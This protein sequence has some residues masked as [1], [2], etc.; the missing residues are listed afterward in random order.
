MKLCAE[1][2]GIVSLQLQCSPGRN[3]PD[4]GLDFVAAARVGVSISIH[5]LTVF[6]G[7]GVGGEDL[8]GRWSSEGREGN[9]VLWPIRGFV[10]AVVGL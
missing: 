10:G 9:G 2:L 8:E 6:D 3:A 7:S 1:R 4:V 5:F